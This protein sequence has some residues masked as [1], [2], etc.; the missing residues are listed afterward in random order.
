MF[1]IDR[2][3]AGYIVRESDKY[4]R[5]QLIQGFN[6]MALANQ[7]FH[8]NIYNNPYLANQ[9]LQLAD[10]DTDVAALLQ[11]KRRVKEKAAP[12]PLERLKDIFFIKEYE[13]IAFGKADH[14]TYPEHVIYE[15]INLVSSEE[16]KTQPRPSKSAAGPEALK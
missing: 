5:N 15:L 1:D 12:L 6:V 14:D 8:V 2:I 16:S 10:C 13:F 4:T 7:L 9:L 11:K 3:C